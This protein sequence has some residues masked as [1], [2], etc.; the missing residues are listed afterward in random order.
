MDSEQ[1]HDL[2]N[3]LEFKV[4][5]LSDEVKLARY[6]YAMAEGR[7]EQRSWWFKLKQFLG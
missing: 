3:Q 7:L 5:Q 2:L 1:I 6:R 4:R